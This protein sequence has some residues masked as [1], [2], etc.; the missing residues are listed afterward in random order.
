MSE[1]PEAIREARDATFHAADFSAPPNGFIQ[2]DRA[3]AMAA[4]LRWVVD[5]VDANAPSAASAYD[6]VMAALAAL[7]AEATK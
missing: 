7:D 6:T 3:S 4:A 5:E 1:L 2:R